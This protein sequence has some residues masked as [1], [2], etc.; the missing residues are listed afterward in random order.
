MAGVT[1]C[2]AARTMSDDNATDA[3]RRASVHCSASSISLRPAP[4]LRAALSIT[5]I[6]P[7]GLIGIETDRLTF[8]IFCY[9]GAEQSKAPTMSE[10]LLS[11]VQKAISGSEIALASDEA[12]LRL[13]SRSIRQMA[14]TVADPLPVAGVL[15]EGVVHLLRKLPVEKRKEAAAAVIQLFADRLTALDMN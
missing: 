9:T 13:L 5:S 2:I 1:A 11:K 8:A 7:S 6:G 12:S 4:G 3:D 10:G 15:L 14:D